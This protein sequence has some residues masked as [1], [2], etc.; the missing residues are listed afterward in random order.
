MPVAPCPRHTQWPAG[1]HGLRRGS[2]RNI[3]EAA[4][5][6]GTAVTVMRTAY[7]DAARLT[8]PVRHAMRTGREGTLL[9]QP[10]QYIET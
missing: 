1:Q 5:R 10:G 9:V 2:S 4:E 3:S 8:E 6:T 7:I